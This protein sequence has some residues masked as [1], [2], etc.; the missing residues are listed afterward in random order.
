MK[1]ALNSSFCTVTPDSKSTLTELHAHVGERWPME[2]T[3]IRISAVSYHDH[4]NNHHHHRY[5]DHTIITT[6]TA[7]MTATSLSP[8]HSYLHSHHHITTVV[9]AIVISIVSISF[10]VVTVVVIIIFVVVVIVI[11]VFFFV[12]VIIIVSWFVPKLYCPPSTVCTLSGSPLSP[13][14]FRPLNSSGR[15]THSWSPLSPFAFRPLNS[16]G[17]VHPQLV[18]SFSI[19]L[20]PPLILRVGFTHSWSPLS[21]FAF[22]PLNSSGRVHSQLVASFSICLSPPQFFGSGSPTAGRLFL[23]LPFAPSILRVGFT[24]SWPL[25]APQWP[26]GKL[27]TRATRNAIWERRSETPW[28]T[29]RARCWLMWTDSPT[30]ESIYS[31]H[32]MIHHVHTGL[33]AE[34]TGSA[35]WC[36]TGLLQ[37]FHRPRPWAQQYSVIWYW[38]NKRGVLS[39][40]RLCSYYFYCYYHN[41]YNYQYHLPLYNY[42]TPTTT[43]TIQLRHYHYNYHYRYHYTTHSQ[44]HHH[45]SRILLLLIVV[46]IA[47]VL[48]LQGK[49]S[50][51]CA[52]T[53]RRERAFLPHEHAD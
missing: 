43:T 42:A 10:I 41:H 26:R 37:T 40:P 30:S 21:P 44:Y 25:L 28:A 6:I 13:F 11:I 33:L 50:S 53:H 46:I 45:C 1:T 2:V 35:F 24:H 52:R 34:K 27:T 16:S 17:R 12:A 8:S 47:V 49:P 4:S 51:P 38:L 32:T 19:C 7:A 23:H 36:Q 14:A 29:G 18:A 48:L 15:F 3:Q 20:S 5:D 22:R 31:M 39:Y 9:N